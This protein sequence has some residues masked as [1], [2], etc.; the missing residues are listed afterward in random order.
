MSSKIDLI[1]KLKRLT[2]SNNIHEAEAA[3][4]KLDY[5]IKKYNISE[6][7]LEESEIKNYKFWYHNKIQKKILIQIIYKVLGSIENVFS[8]KKKG[9]QI[10]LF[11]S[12][13][14]EQYIDISV[15][16]EFYKELIEEELD[17]FITAFIMKHNIY[18]NNSDDARDIKDLTDEELNKYKRAS[19][20]SM[21]M[22]NT[23]SV[24]KRIESK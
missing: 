23:K 9:K 18:P 6:K 5:I 17:I 2:Y 19:F 15:Q 10:E 3:Q 8:Y 12:C 24:H 14:Y 22:D 11:V 20:M 7:E 21:A 13:T 16:Y 1:N 4:K